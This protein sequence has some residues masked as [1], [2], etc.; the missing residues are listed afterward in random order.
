MDILFMTNHAVIYLKSGTPNLH[1]YTREQFLEA[2]GIQ[3]HASKPVYCIFNTCYTM[4]FLVATFNLVPSHGYFTETT[5]CML[6]VNTNIAYVK[7]KYLL[8]FKPP[9]I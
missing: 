3:A 1:L 4:M 6:N 7:T 2:S 8:T 9:F 5:I